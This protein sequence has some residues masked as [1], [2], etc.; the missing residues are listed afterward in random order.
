MPRVSA[1]LKRAVV[2]GRT[3]IDVRVWARQGLLRP[4]RSFHWSWRHGVEPAGGIEVV[5]TNDAVVLRFCWR[6]SDTERWKSFEQFVPLTSTRC[7]LG[8]ARVWFRCTAD[9]GGGQYCNQRA[10]KLYLRGHVFAC[11]QCCG[12]AYESQS[13]NPRFRA[14]RKSQKIRIRLGGRANLLDPFPDKPRNMRW[15]TYG[16][17]FDQAEVAQARWINLSR[18]FLR[19]HTTPTMRPTPHP[20]IPY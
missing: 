18:D 4:G 3:S 19:R 17:L 15:R 9:I 11:R 1:Q 12:L 14:I 7:H 13:E 5:S 8:G 6:A 20:N 16:R 2:E 10:A